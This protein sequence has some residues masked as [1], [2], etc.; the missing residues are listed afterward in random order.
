VCVEQSLSLSPV[1]TSGRQTLVSE[2]GHSHTSALTVASRHLAMGQEVFLLGVPD[3]DSNLGLLY[4]IM[5][6][7]TSGGTPWMGDQTIANPVPSA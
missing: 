7:K 4:C 6:I 5:I 1:E 2:R 3:M